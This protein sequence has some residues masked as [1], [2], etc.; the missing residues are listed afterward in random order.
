VL[1]Q[2]PVLIQSATKNIAEKLAAHLTSQTSFKKLAPVRM[3]ALIRVATNAEVLNSLKSMNVFSYH[4]L[5]KIAVLMEHHSA[6]STLNV[7]Q[8]KTAAMPPKVNNGAQSPT[9]ARLL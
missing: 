5:K 2:K 7:S 6:H 1:N 9:N 4:R 3:T 8:L